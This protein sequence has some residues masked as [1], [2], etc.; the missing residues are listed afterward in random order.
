MSHEPNKCPI[1]NRFYIV[2]REEPQNY[3]ACPPCRANTVFNG[4]KE[5]INGLVKD[6]HSNSSDNKASGGNNCK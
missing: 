6:I 2:E 4:L 1:C 3:M 5:R